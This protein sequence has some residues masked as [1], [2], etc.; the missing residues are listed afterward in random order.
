MNWLRKRLGEVSTY[1]G[2]VL[3]AVGGAG[4]LETLS[5]AGAGAASM[6][7]A[8]ALGI[9]I[10]GIFAMLKGEKPDWRK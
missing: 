5:D 8:T 9:V 3:T 7:F 2:G 10:L 4:A 6:E 1:A